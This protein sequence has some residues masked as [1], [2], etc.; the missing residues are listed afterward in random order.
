MSIATTSNGPVGWNGCKGRLC[1]GLLLFYAQ[2]SQ[3]ATAL[4]TSMT[5]FGRSNP[6]ALCRPCVVVPVDRKLGDNG[7]RIGSVVAM[8]AVRA[9]VWLHQCSRVAQGLCFC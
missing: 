5:M 9:S 8:T 6:V 4:Y 7:I 1:F 2:L 3:L